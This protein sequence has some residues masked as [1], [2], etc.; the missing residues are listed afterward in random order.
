MRIG[1][2]N[3]NVIIIE[4]CCISLDKNAASLSDHIYCGLLFLNTFT[5]QGLISCI[6]LDLIG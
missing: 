3:F 5:K 4:N 6:F 2:I 1:M